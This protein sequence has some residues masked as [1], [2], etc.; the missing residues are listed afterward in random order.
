[1]DEI[2]E[3]LNEA[4]D[5]LRELTDSTTPEEAAASSDEPT[6]QVFWRD[7]PHVSAW[8][9]SLWRRLNESLA[10]AAE[11]VVDSEVDETGG[12]D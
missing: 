8:A 1:M 5:L 4:L 11:P 6:L 3:R 2:S 7:W 12:G 10:E 9:G